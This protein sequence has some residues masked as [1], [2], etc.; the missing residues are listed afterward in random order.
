MVFHFRLGARATE[1][2]QEGS[3]EPEWA[4]R[5]VAVPVCLCATLVKCADPNTSGD[6]RPQ[7]SLFVPVSNRLGALKKFAQAT[8]KLWDIWENVG[9]SIEMVMYLCSQSWV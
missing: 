5:S 3:Q 7:P 2:R 4:A 6:T 8:A 9:H 1:L